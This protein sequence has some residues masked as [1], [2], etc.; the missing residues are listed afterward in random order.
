MK[1]KLSICILLGVATFGFAAAG[2]RADDEEKPKGPAEP[3]AVTLMTADGVILACT[4]YQSPKCNDDKG[5]EAAP[6]ILLPGEK[7]NRKQL[8]GFATDLQK[9][10]HAVITVDLRGMGDSRSTVTGAEIPPPDEMKRT[11]LPGMVTQDL[12]AVKNFL[13]EK[14]NAGELNMEMLGLVASDMSTIMALNWVVQNWSW[15][16]FPGRRQGK[17]IKALV[18][19]SPIRTYSGLTST[20]TLITPQVR[21]QSIMIVYGS[22]DAKYRSE[23]KRIHDSLKRGRVEPDKTELKTLFFVEKRTTLQG[24]D[25]LDKKLGLKVDV[26]IA[27]FFQLRLTNNADRF[28]WVYRGKKPEAVGG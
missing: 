1:M 4:Y 5:K 18:L 26:Y 3:E 22:E 15:P 27:R 8:D 24:N 7:G 17:D 19:L 11:E 13:K 10:G 2:L 21:S 16:S 28:P 12:V 20:P 23:A 9:I 14:N 6:I 25:L